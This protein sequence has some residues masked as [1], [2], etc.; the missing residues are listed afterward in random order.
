MLTLS[1]KLNE[2]ICIGDNII[3]RVKE[4]RSNQVRIGIS[5]PKGIKIFREEIWKRMRG[6]NAN[7]GV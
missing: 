4:I 6:K 2:G 7:T 5:A 1:R 3:I